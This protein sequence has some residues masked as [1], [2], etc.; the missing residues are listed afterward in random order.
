MNEAIPV[1]APDEHPKENRGK[2]TVFLGAAPGVGKTYTM[3]E[4]AHE[5]VQEGLI[6]MIGRVDT[7]GF[8]ELDRLIAMLPQVR[9]R[10]SELDGLGLQEMDI[11]AIIKLKPQLVLVDDLAYTNAPGKDLIS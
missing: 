3:L 8:S 5:R 1:E 7:H 10:E 9:T 2:L 11:D 4:A 6:V